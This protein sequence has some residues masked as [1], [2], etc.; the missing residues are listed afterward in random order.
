MAH[1]SPDEGPDDESGFRAPLPPDDRLW[2]HPSEIRSEH[3]FGP[4]PRP[5]TPLGGLGP[6][7]FPPTGDIL[8]EPPPAR[9]GRHARPALVGLAAGAAGALLTVGAL[10][11]AGA[12][13]GDAPARE[14]V[15]EVVQP[16][17]LGGA[18]TP[19]GDVVHIAEEVSPA[20]T[21]IVAA[22]DT[23]SG[24]S[25][26]IVRGDGYVVTNA[27]VVDEAH[28]ITVVLADGSEHHGDL[29]GLDP[30]TDIAVVKISRDEGY[31]PAPLGTAGDLRVGQVAVAI[32]SPLGLEGGSSVTTGVISQ[33]GRVVQAE[34]R[35]AL[36]DMIQTDA[37]IA[38]GSSGG[39]LLDGNGSV[40]GITTAIA[41]SD[42]GAEGLG[43]AV[44]IDIARAVAD[45][46]IETGRAVHVWLGI[47]GVTLDQRRSGTMSVPGGAVVQEVVPGSPADD[48]GLTRGDVIL[49]VG[50][51][52]V[53]SMSGL[54]I[55]L[56]RLGPGDTVALTVDRSGDRRT[57]PVTLAERPPD[58]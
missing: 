42:V 10:G 55:A 27:H 6:P 21:R 20:I 32:G 53:I 23:T 37:A 15:R 4:P 44:P 35:P 36:L 56:R 26:V 34:D 2:R 24:G 57:V 13:D 25:G 14:I 1:G 3:G 30:Q 54:V 29:V 58:D 22:G 48:A 33:L 38:P 12:L 11:L 16:A 51:D 39:A 41:V 52:D 43:F 45:D 19:T 49:G 9:A 7:L 28:T 8:P 47:E 50:D 18:T 31:T 40:I 46:I 5:S 17:Q